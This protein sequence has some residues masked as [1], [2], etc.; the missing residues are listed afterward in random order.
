MSCSWQPGCVGIFLG[1]W[2]LTVTMCVVVLTDTP[3]SAKVMWNT[4]GFARLCEDRAH[5]VKR[6]K[7]IWSALELKN[8]FKGIT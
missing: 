5:L 4:S 3:V 1:S 7:G 2:L 6:E 8:R